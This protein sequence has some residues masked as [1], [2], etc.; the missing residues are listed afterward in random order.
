MAASNSDLFRKG[1][2]KWV[3]QIGAAGVADAVVTTIPLTSATG[4]PTDTGVEIVINRVDSAG[5]KTPS[6]EE[7]VVGVVSGDNL[8]SCVRGVEGT[9]QAHSGGSVVE[10]LITNDMWNDVVDGI[11]AEHAQDGAH[12]DITGTTITLTGDLEASAISASS[13]TVSSFVDACSI[14]AS[15]ITLG[16]TTLV[17]G[18]L[19]EDDLCSNSATNLSTQQSIKAYVD[20]NAGASEITEV[21][22]Q[23]KASNSTPDNTVIQF[24]WDSVQGSGTT[25]T[26]D[27]IVF[28]AEFDSDP[29]V[30]ITPVGS[31]ITTDSA[32]I[33][34]FGTNAVV[35]ATLG[36]VTTTGCNVRMNTTDASNMP[37]STYFAYT[38]TAYGSIA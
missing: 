34:D 15:H 30:V 12:T 1:A 3:G 18:I 5:T 6:A 29:I 4:L 11:L 26:S 31:K 17:S 22:R 8:V 19:D 2:R 33:S 13:V 25:V 36:A 7:T 37:S 38:W 32:D 23:D 21:H 10:V 35:N 27:T 28:P 16:G 9:A 24:G 14:T 20:S